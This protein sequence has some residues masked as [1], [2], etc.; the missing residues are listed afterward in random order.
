VSAPEVCDARFSDGVDYLCFQVVAQLERN[1][2]EEDPLRYTS[3]EGT[4]KFPCA[5][6]LVKVLTSR[7][8]RIRGDEDFGPR[9]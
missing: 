1:Q 2:A 5:S 9:P 6:C 8:H 3:L 4:E 7:A